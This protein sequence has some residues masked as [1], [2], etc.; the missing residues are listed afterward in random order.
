MIKKLSYLVIFALSLFLASCTNE[1]DTVKSK[2]VDSDH[3]ILIFS[4]TEGW[5]HDSI[6]AGHEAITKIAS[7]NNVSVTSTEDASYFTTDN[8]QNYEAVV[9]LNT[10]ETIFNDNQREAFKNYIQSGGGFVGIHSA[11][12]TE[13]DWPWYNNLVGAYFESH[14]NNPNVRE[15]ALIVHNHNHTSTSMLPERW[16]RA[17]EWY[18]FQDLNED[19]TV[20]ISLDTDSYEGS[21]HPGNHPVAWFHEFDGGRSFYT[22]LGH[23]IDSFS[24]EL[25]L[26]HLWGGIEYSMGREL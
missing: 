5:R 21:A 10:T 3:K 1:R 6:E 15:A 2:V 8:L 13:Y 26:D 20:L 24:E 16:E 23:T 7:E 19:V 17:D 12:D 18:N 4:K 9:F 25:F 11:S 22:A 14:P